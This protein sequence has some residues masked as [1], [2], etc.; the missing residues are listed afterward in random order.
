[1]TIAFIRQIEDTLFQLEQITARAKK[2]NSQF[3]WRIET[4]RDS[5]KAVSNTYHEVL[6]RDASEDATYTP[7][8]E[9]I[10]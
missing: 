4:A 7:P 10:K 8:L 1:M 9:R 6:Q 5:I 3:R 2:E